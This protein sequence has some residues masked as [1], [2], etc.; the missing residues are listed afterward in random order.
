[1]SSILLS[2]GISVEPW[3]Q[4][5]VVKA[6][7]GRTE[8]AF[9]DEHNLLRHPERQPS[10]GYSE[11]EVTP[12]TRA[13]SPV[14][15]DD[16]QLVLSFSN[17]PKDIATGFILGSDRTKSDIIIGSRKDGISSRHFVINFDERGRIV[18]RD[19]SKKGSYVSYNRQP[20]NHRAPFIWMLP[21]GYKVAVSIKE[22]RIEFS[23]D[24]PTH[25]G[26]LEQYGAHLTR[27]L[28]L[29]S[30]AVP[31]FA[32]LL[33]A[34]SASTAT[35]ITP[36]SAVLDSQTTNSQATNTGPVYVLD[37]KIGSGQ[38]GQV[39][40]VFNAS[41]WQVYAAKDIQPKYMASEV[42]TLE[43]LSHVRN[44]YFYFLYSVHADNYT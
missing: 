1:M 12:S 20:Y 13:S 19:I 5:L 43:K 40:K 26:H 11:R 27:Y 37:V 9:N 7:N 44:S 10:P 34:S 35:T 18:M 30:R 38:F 39:F 32:N 41:T 36:Q 22:R 24:V 16:V 2:S 3:Q 42:L 21:P 33:I 23:I 29:S 4:I 15:D 8:R 14:D 31:S 6:I 25:T 28:D 17:P